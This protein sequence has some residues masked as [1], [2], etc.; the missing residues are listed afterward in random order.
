MTTMNKDEIADGVCEIVGELI[1]K[2]PSHIDRTGSLIEQGLDSLEVTELV[3]Q[4]EDRFGIRFEQT[5]VWDNDSI[6]R[7]SDTI[8]TQFNQ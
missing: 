5:V 2:E 3:C 8:F 6:D 1:G 7:L 4:I